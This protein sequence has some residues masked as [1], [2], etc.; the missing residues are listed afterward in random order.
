MK[1][2]GEK[3][4]MEHIYASLL[5]SAT[6]HAELIEGTR[7]PACGSFAAASEF[8]RIGSLP[9]DYGFR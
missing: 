9:F 4:F 1:H 2:A 6:K 3:E 5:M 7:C 8:A